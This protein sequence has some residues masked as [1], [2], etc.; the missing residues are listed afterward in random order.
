MALGERELLLREE[1]R[2][3]LPLGWETQR[4]RLAPVEL[5]FTLAI[6]IATGNASQR[7]VE[8]RVRRGQA[9]C[10]GGTST[11]TRTGVSA[12]LTAGTGQWMLKVRREAESRVRW[13]A[14]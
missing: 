8:A 5:A 3:S 6:A 9:A 14:K 1:G 12:G 10:A 7:F 2:R 13:G 4:E 11:R